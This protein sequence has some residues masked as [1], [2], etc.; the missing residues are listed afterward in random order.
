MGRG[1]NQTFQTI[2]LKPVLAKCL[3][4]ERCFTK[5]TSD[6]ECDVRII[7]FYL[8]PLTF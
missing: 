7:H 3:R 5:I 6:E 1:V 8:S 2:F 4:G